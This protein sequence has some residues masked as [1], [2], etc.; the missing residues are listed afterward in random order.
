M[1]Y[2]VIG[3]ALALAATLPATTAQAQLARTFIASFGT[4]TGTCGRTAPCRT[5]AF[6]YGQTAVAGEINLLDSAGFG[7]LTITHSISVIGNGTAGVLVPAGGTGITINAGAS[8]DKINLRGLIIEGGGAGA[9]GISFAS[10]KS[11]TITN[12]VVRNLTNSGLALA[13]T[14]SS[15]ISVSDTLIAD[16]GN[17]GAYAQPVGSDISVHVV[18]N[19]VQAHNNGVDGIVAYS[20]F[21]SGGSLWTLTTD[22]KESIASKN[23]GAGFVVN[24]SRNEMKIDRS[25]SSGNGTALVADAGGEMFISQVT[26]TRNLNICWSITSGDQSTPTGTIT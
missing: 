15:A 12:S 14:N 5:L 2:I 23:G 3:A 8:G 19:R 25:I 17:L 7:T 16:N 21:M 22:V 1:K 26:A 24:G 11:L 9:F 18:F 4:D 6:A 13:P 10:G 20:N